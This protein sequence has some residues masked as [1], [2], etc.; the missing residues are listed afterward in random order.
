MLSEDEQKGQIDAL[1]GLKSAL[2]DIKKSRLEDLK[3]VGFEGLGPIDVRIKSAYITG[4][5]DV[6]QSLY[7]AIDNEIEKMK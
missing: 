1:K 7:E 2:L 3:E 4:Q 6:C 5:I